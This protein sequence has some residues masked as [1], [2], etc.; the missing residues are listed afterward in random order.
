MEKG[1]LSDEDQLKY[2]KEIIDFKEEIDLDY[3]MEEIDDLIEGIDHGAERTA[4]IVQGLRNFS[5]LDEEDFKETDLEE[6]LDSTLI[7]L[8]S[9][10]RNRVEI[11]KNYGGIPRVYCNGGKINQVFMNLMSNA[12]DAID[13]RKQQEAD[14]QAKMTISTHILN[15][16]VVEIRIGD[17]GIGMDEEV[18]QRI[19]EPFYTTKDVGKGTGL[20][21]S[22]VYKILQ[23]HK[24]KLQL[25]SEP[26]KGSIFRLHIP[27]RYQSNR[28]E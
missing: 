2:I 1:G 27:I 19:F 28:Q 8:N 9:R 16:Q 3:V 13:E 6:G 21:L 7:L 10:I 5:R 12:L 4:S 15:D 23:N 20:G 17:N 18:K 22:I 24:A 26:K 11:E 14:L 25:E